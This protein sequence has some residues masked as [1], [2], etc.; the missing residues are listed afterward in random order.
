[1]T[2][3]NP[4]NGKAVPL[5]TADYVLAG[6]GCGAVMAVP[7]H[8]ERDF[9]FARKY[10]LP[11]VP[12]IRPEDAEPL[13]PDRMEN[14]YTAPGVMHDSGPFDGVNSVEGIAKTAAHAQE[15]GFGKPSVTY[16]LRDW[17]LSRQ[18]YWGAPIP[19]VHCDGCG[20][21]PVP[22]KDL[23]V[24]LPRVRDFL[25][26]GRSPLEDVP[27]FMNT[28][29]PK[30]GQAARRDPDTM[31]TFVCSSWYHLR[32][33]DPKNADRPWEKEAI[34]DWLPVDFY[35]GGSEH[36]MGHLIYFRFITKVL[37]DLGYDQGAP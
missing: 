13:D 36:A 5:Y 37:H 18:R 31:D 27:E 12:V 16:R 20:V 25:P 4:F 33:S 6:Y 14:A 15:N 34:D 32:Y 26:K 28:D 2:V 23:P 10:G 29:C 3:L 7:A 22:E 21:V 8:D 30:C 19:V 35:I 24:V 17:L 1:L 11:I 9:A